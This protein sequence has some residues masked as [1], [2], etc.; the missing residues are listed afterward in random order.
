MWT[1]GFSTEE[2]SRWGKS[3]KNKKIKSTQPQR[4]EK[5]ICSLWSV[6]E[7]ERHSSPHLLT[8]SYGRFP[9]IQKLNGGAGQYN[10]LVFWP[11]ATRTKKSTHEHTTE[12]TLESYHNSLYKF[13]TDRTAIG[14]LLHHRVVP[15]LQLTAT[16]LSGRV[17][18]RQVRRVNTRLSDCLY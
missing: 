7:W 18:P 17:H 4:R 6:W 9:L 13:C 16:V 8:R 3:L 1:L 12:F 5:K 14:E 11:W 15:W 2:R 10:A